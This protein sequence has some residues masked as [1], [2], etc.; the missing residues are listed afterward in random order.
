MKLSEQ[1][2]MGDIIET[3]GDLKEDGVVPK[4]IKIKVDTIIQDL[5][6]ESEI[7]MKV[8]KALNELD[9]ISDDPNLQAYT[10]TQIWNIV[11]MLEKF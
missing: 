8:N 5:S 4:N 6:Q 3:L 9:E 7:S 2:L 10:R 1:D 11:S